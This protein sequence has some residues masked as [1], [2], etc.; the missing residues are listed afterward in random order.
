MP[1][2]RFEGSDQ[3]IEVGK[4][5]NLRRSLLFHGRS[6]HKGFEQVVNCRGLGAC[7][8][9]WVEVLEGEENLS[10]PTKMEQLP[11]SPFKKIGVKGRR[12]SCQTRVYG[13][14]LIRLHSE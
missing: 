8:T 4:G 5:A 11:T 7:G 12:L 9:C 10:P 6:P 1:T 2:I 14:C 13:D 3:S